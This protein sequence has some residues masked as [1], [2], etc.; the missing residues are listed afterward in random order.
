[1]TRRN[2]LGTCE[3][4]RHATRSDRGV[5]IKL[6]YVT[7][8]FGVIRVSAS[9]PAALIFA[10]DDLSLSQNGAGI[11]AYTIGTA[12]SYRPL[13]IPHILG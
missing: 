11:Y 2:W 7:S 12:P 13:F 3:V 4:L 8:L 9:P 10:G 5:R 1:M 6:V